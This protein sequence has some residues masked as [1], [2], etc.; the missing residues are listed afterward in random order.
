MSAFD[1]YIALVK[2]KF[3]EFKSWMKPDPKDSTL[4]QIIKFSSK[5]PL[6]LLAVLLSPLAITLLI[7]AFIAAF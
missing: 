3:Q 4:I 6:V 2:E 5:V 7:F 1:P